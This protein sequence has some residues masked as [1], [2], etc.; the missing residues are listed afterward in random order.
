M[1]ARPWRERTTPRLPC[2]PS[3]IVP[4]AAAFIAQPFSARTRDRCVQLWLPADASSTHT[5]T[6]LRPLRHGFEAVS[7][8]IEPDFDAGQGRNDRATL[9]SS[10]QSLLVAPAGFPLTSTTTRRTPEPASLA[11]KVSACEPVCTAPLSRVPP[12]IET[13]GAVGSVRL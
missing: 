1:R 8:L 3:V 7:S 5:R 6:E 13:A 9:P 12:E 4:A 11:S 10:L 2:Q